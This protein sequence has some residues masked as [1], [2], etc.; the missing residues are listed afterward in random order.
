MDD[1]TGNELAGASLQVSDPEGTPVRAWI[2]RVD[3]GFV[4]KG[5]QPDTQYTITENV[6]REGYLVN[7]TG[8]LWRQ[9]TAFSRSR[10][11]R[12]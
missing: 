11:A 12:R 6:P 1:L 4:I 7:F 5:L 2:T 9:K 10:T 8:H 3:G